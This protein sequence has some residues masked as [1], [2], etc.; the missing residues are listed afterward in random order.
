MAGETADIVIVGSGIIGMSAAYELARRGAGRIVV[1]E[2][3]AGVASGSTGA[4][5]AILRLRY[6]H[7]ETMR[8]ALHGQ[9][10]Y[11]DWADYTGLSNP[12]ASMREV[13]VLWM[14]GESISTI[15]RERD[16]IEQIGGRARLLTGADLAARFPSVSTCATPI[17][18]VDGS[19]HACGEADSFLFEDEGGYCTDPAGAAQDLL[20]A[21][22]RDG[23]EVRFHAPVADVRTSGGRVTGVTLADGRTIDGPCV[24]NAAGPWC[25]RVNDMAGLEHEWPL[26]PTRIQVML[27]A[28]VE[29]LPGGIPM[30]ADAAGG[31]YL[32]PESGGQQLLVG[33]IR[34]EDE[35]EPIDDPDAYDTGLDE[36]RRIAL[37]HGLHHRIPELVHRGRVTGVAGM[38]TINRHDV[39]PVVGRTHI[40]GFHVSN[41][42]SGH[43]FKLGPAVGNLLAQIITGQI[44]D[45]DVPISHDFLSIDRTP[46]QVR[47]KGVLA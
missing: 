15:E 27:R 2:K 23:V 42:Y 3:A 30:I 17:D 32:R 16:R 20:E 36:S 4:S 9:R 35:T 39:H 38:Y 19:D 34:T 40:D 5:S 10:I 11:R 1:L 18:L 31:I 44:E 24:V 37:L 46:L 45:G 13:G 22:R 21:C 33:S 26:V 8:M 6:S 12:R 47:E 43:G 29:P 25:N 41:G 14:L 7:T 28:T